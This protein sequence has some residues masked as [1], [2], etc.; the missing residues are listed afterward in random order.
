MGG[1]RPQ[2]TR[3]AHTT[4]VRP[5]LIERVRP[6]GGGGATH[7]T[8]LRA[9]CVWRARRPH[10]TRF[11]G[12]GVLPTSGFLGHGVSSAGSDARRVVVSV[13]HASMEDTPLRCAV[14]PVGSASQRRGA[15]SP[16]SP[17]R[18]AR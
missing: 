5:L 1:V 8:G 13:W 12:L 18:E 6:A 7:G 2:P 14:T 4:L 15:V 9:G 3:L 10:Q 11:Y 17:L 16:M